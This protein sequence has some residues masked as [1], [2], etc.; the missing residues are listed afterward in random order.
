MVRRDLLE[1]DVSPEEPWPTIENPPDPFTDDWW[2]L[3]CRKDIHRSR[4]RHLK[5]IG[6]PGDYSDLDSP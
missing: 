1:L 2:F 6:I 5:R 3:L 4:P